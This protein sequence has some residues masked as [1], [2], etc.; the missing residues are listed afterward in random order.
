MAVVFSVHHNG[1]DYVRDVGGC[2]NSK[3]NVNKIMQKIGKHFN[4]YFKSNSSFYYSRSL[5]S[6]DRFEEKRKQVFDRRSSTIKSLLGRS[7]STPVSIFG[8]YHS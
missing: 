3:T 5:L 4:F 6:F 7:P 2:I 1:K 8:I